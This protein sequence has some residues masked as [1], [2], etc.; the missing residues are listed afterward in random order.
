MKWLKLYLYYT[1]VQARKKC[2]GCDDESVPFN[3]QHILEVVQKVD[4]IYGNLEG[5][6]Q[7][8]LDRQVG[9]INTNIPATDVF[10]KS[11]N[12]HFDAME[13]YFKRIGLDITFDT[14][15]QQTVEYLNSF[16]NLTNKE[17]LLTNVEFIAFLSKN[18][19]EEVKRGASRILADLA[20]LSAAEYKGRL[21]GTIPLVFPYNCI[22]PAIQSVQ[23]KGLDT[24]KNVVKAVEKAKAIINDASSSSS[25]SKGN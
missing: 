15:R 18:S 10:L 16:K 21:D 11:A 24:V 17:Q 12:V 14:L 3:T 20:G 19:Y 8:G 23:N 25:C 1:G 6:G 9:Y 13:A 5:Q 4:S 7:G 2:L 22:F